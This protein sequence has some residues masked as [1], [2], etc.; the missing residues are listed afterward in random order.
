MDRICEALVGL[1][2]HELYQA[3]HCIDGLERQSAI[4]AF[5]AACWKDQVA[6]RLV[7]LAL[8]RQDQADG[9]HA[10]AS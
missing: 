1:K 9:N 10:R 6:A 5:G 4:S 7:G 2:A 8:Q 3:W